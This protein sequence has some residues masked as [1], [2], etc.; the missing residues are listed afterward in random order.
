MLRI[1]LHW[2][3]YCAGVSFPILETTNTPLHQV[4]AEWIISMRKYL[5]KIQG[6]LQIANASVPPKMREHDEYIMDI[7]MDTKKFKPSQIRRI[8]Y[9]RMYL[10]VTTLS[11]ITNATGDIIDPA[12]IVGKRDQM[13]APS[14]WKRIY[15]HKPDRSSWAIWR[16]VL[17]HVSYKINKKYHLIQPLDQLIIAREHIRPNWSHWQDQQSKR[18]YHRVENQIREHH[19]LWYDYN[20]D[21]YQ[22]IPQMP[23]TTVPVDV[24]DSGIIW[25]V[26]PHY[27]TW[28]PALEPPQHQDIHNVIKQLNG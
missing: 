11:D 6:Q 15:Q 21:E 5:N 12:A 17:Q 22:V 16:K 3:Q 20:Q 25:R 18:L 4:E 2:A 8:N 14:Q 23:T 7:A 1:A 26:K 9:C 13:M 24:E 19:K 10:N 28:T 27:N